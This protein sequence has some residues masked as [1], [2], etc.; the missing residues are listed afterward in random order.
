MINPVARDSFRDKKINKIPYIT[1][2]HWTLPEE[3]DISDL[4]FLLTDVDLLLAVTAPLDTGYEAH[5]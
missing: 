5:E 4:P 1:L 3:Y 2:N